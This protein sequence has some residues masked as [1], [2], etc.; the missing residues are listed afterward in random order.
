MKSDCPMSSPN[1]ESPTSFKSLIDVIPLYLNAPLFLKT[2]INT[3][4]SLWYVP[5]FQWTHKLWLFWLDPIH[6]ILLPHL[7]GT[8][9]TCYLI[10]FVILGI[11]WVEIRATVSQLCP[12]SLSLSLFFSFLPTSPLS[13]IFLI[14][15]QPFG[16][17]VRSAG[18]FFLLKGFFF[19]LHS[20]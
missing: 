10:V 4:L 9:T 11:S 17:D 2:M 19:S 18:D 12:L 13:P 3:S 16:A 6:T 14:S 1:L 5:S 15:A 8:L 7:I 20:R